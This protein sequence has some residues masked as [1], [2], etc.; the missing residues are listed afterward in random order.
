MEPSNVQRQL[1]EILV[2][3]FRQDDQSPLRSAERIDPRASFS[4][5]GINSVDLLEFVLRVEERF[6]VSL[7]D[8]LEPSDLPETVA[9][10]SAW[11][12][13]RPEAV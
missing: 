13:A 11:L 6:D 9:D 8:E 10:W 2:D 1:I 3:I 12:A 5:Q 7:L 4:E